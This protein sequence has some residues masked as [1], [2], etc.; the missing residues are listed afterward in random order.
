[1]GVQ[2]IKHEAKIAEWTEKMQQ[3]RSSGKSVKGRCDEQRI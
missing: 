2:A 1:M 3:Y